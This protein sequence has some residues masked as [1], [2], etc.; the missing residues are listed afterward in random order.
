MNYEISLETK[1]LGEWSLDE[2]ETKDFVWTLYKL[3]FSVYK[4]FDDEICFTATD[5]QVTE[6]KDE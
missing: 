3:G 1:D 4:G 5:E 2:C 6:I